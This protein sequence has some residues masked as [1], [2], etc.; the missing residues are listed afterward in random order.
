MSSLIFGGDTDL[1]LDELSLL[2]DTLLSTRPLLLDALWDEV[3]L[4]ALTL[5]PSIGTLVSEPWLLPC[6]EF[7]LF[8]VAATTG[9]WCARAAIGSGT[10][11]LPECALK[12]VP[13]VAVGF[14]GVATVST[15]EIKEILGEAFFVPVAVA[16]NAEPCME[17][18]VLLGNTV[19]WGVC[20]VLDAL[21]GGLLLLYL[22]A[23]S[24][25][26]I[27]LRL[28]SVLVPDGTVG[29]IIFPA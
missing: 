6:G 1:A 25:F 4:L 13:V 22:F 24:D 18:T 11:L 7:L 14:E 28:R 29:G 16:E 17:G 2:V 23:V 26:F 27:L 10:T 20:A 3:M 21:V 12:A 8:D 15:C 19:F 5:S 9:A